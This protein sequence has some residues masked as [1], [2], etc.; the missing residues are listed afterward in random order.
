VYVPGTSALE[1]ALVDAGNWYFLN[2]DA[3]V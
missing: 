1:T 2:A 3:D